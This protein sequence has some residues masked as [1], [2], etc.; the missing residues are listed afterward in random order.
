[1]IGFW[2]NA[3]DKLLGG[4]SGAPPFKHDPVTAARSIG[5][6]VNFVN[7]PLT[8]S[9]ADS[10]SALSA[11]QKSNVIIFFGGIDNTIEK[12]SQ[13]RT[14]IAWPAGQLSVLQRLAALNKPI[15]VVK[16]GTHVDDTPLLSLPNI[17][18]ILWAGYPGQDGGTAVMN[19]IT[20]AAAPAG[21]LPMTMY[22]SSFTSAASFTNMALRPSGSSYPGR[23]YRWY[24][25][26]V[27]PFGH[28]LHYT[29][30]NTSIGSF[31]STF[32]IPDL[33]A[34]CK[35]TGV[36]YLDL[37]PF[38]ALPVT[39]INTGSRTSDYVALAF[40]S[41]DFGP[42]PYPIKTLAAYTRLSK[43]AP[44]V[45]KSVALDWNLGS[46]ARVDDKGNTVLYPGTYTVLVDQPMV[47]NMSF[48]LTGTEAV[49]DKWPQ[50]S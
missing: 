9:S 14:S 34:S 6:A 47:A 8:Q 41:G 29:T 16:L 11:A 50:P 1:M 21:R 7:G 48:T 25:T 23:T 27:F 38:P 3:A 31:P 4:Y 40:L 42:A 19:L 26:P 22:P 5:I 49:L 18:A 37:C 20:G 46:L 10:S 39:V 30:F 43:L 44:G 28:G 35:A 15:I 2:A 36:R 45:S 12:E 32:S 13:D 33:V 24:K 17:K